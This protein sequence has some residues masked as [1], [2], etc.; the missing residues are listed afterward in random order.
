MDRTKARRNEE[1]SGTAGDALQRTL[2]RAELLEQVCRT[3][4]LSH[5]EECIL[6]DA[7][8][9]T[10][11][12]LPENGASGKGR[13]LSTCA[14]DYDA[15]LRRLTEDCAFEAED[16]EA[17]C[18]LQLDS[19]LPRLRNGER[20]SV[21][22]RLRGEDGE[23]AWKRVEY[24]FFREDGRQILMLVA[25]IQEEENTRQRLLDA[26][27]AAEAAS[28][29]KSAFLANMSHEIRTPMNAI[30]GISEVL[31]RRDLPQDVLEAL[32]TI[33]NSGSSLLGIINDIL[34]FSKIETGKFEITDV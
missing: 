1:T 28:R 22:L 30:V 34:D 8:S 19:L 2:E 13:F 31:L 5:Y 15:G 6:I 33:Q 16:R 21:R 11:R 24:S 26:A 9:R 10:V 17:L 20:V 23:A 18:A 4:V 25:D 14:E 27:E 12:A 32:S 3:A 29:A 7:G